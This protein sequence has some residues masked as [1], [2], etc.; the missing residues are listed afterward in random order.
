MLPTIIF[1]LA[2]LTSILPFIIG[3]ILE[4]TT[5]SR[6]KQDLYSLPLFIIPIVLWSYLFYLLH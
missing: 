4:D 6:R 5:L 2:L 3:Y 1:F